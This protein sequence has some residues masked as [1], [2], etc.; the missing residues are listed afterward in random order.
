[1]L[2]RAHE[3]SHGSF[4][5]DPEDRR[6][7]VET[8]IGNLVL[9]KAW[10][11]R[12]WVFTAS[13]RWAMETHGYFG[14]SKQEPYP[15]ITPA[16]ESVSE[17]LLINHLRSVFDGQ[18]NVSPGQAFDEQTRKM[19]EVLPSLTKFLLTAKSVPKEVRLMVE[20]IT[21]R[22]EFAKM[23][24]LRFGDPSDQNVNFVNMYYKNNLS[25]AQLATDLR[26]LKDIL[27]GFNTNLVLLTYAEI[28]NRGNKKEIRTHKRNVV[29]RVW[30][31]IWHNDDYSTESLEIYKK[32]LMQTL[33]DC[34]NQLLKYDNRLD[35][36]VKKNVNR[37]P[38]NRR[39]SAEEL[40]YEADGIKYVRHSKGRGSKDNV[41]MVAIKC[42]CP[43]R[44]TTANP[45]S[46]K[47]W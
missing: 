4:I 33:T 40:L 1:M 13:G 41:G 17:E 21:D 15:D 39:K 16:G 9:A 27:E 44:D 11:D 23:I 26:F 8:A 38:A 43:K 6:S 45:R 22:S 7:L 46:V 2:K 35:E 47:T 34:E 3:Q 42:A 14:E 18:P 25:E 24:A 29:D 20:N 30:K 28:R 12:G 31:G 10:T 37:L 5:I 19:N 36:K 32:A